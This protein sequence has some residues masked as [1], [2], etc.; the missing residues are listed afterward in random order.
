MMVTDSTFLNVAIIYRPR[1]GKIEIFCS[2]YVHVNGM[3]SL[4]ELMSC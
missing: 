2:M 1:Y 3:L 4:L